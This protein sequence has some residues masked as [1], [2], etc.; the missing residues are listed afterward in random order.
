MN[1]RRRL[2]VVAFGLMVAVAPPTRA[3][4]LP[5]FTLTGQNWSYN[6]GD[7]GSTITGILLTPYT[8]VPLPAV[9]ISHGKGGSAGGFS[10]PKA[11]LMTNWGLVCIGPDY[12]H[13]GA[14]S[15]P[16][17][18]GYCPENSR[19]ARA[20]LTILRSLAYVDTNRLA[21]Y[22]N[23][24]GAFL[25]AGFCGEPASP[26]RAAAI[27]AGGTS[28]TANTN[29][30]SPTVSEVN[31]VRAPFLLL[32]GTADTTVPP[33]QSA[34]LQAVLNSNGVPN[35]R[36]LFGD[37]GHDL[38]NNPATSNE[39]NQLIREWF[40]EWGVLPALQLTVTR[41]SSNARVSWPSGARD[42]FEVQHRGAL[43]AGS[44]Q[45]VVANWPAGVSNRTQWIHTNALNDG[46]GFYR[47]SRSP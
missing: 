16:E 28:G 8:N 32:H 19:R 2:A 37:I 27:T 24:M 10:L 4:G 39:V 44:W 22:G 30:A 33:Q 11:R 41:E 38:H 42:R 18:E 12:T 26:L 3:Q 13:A 14:G 35:S 15:T 45:P 40:T 36:V 20:C 5:G 34:S 7:G 9:L 1:T 43:D 31:A 6:P 23:S 29:F 17:N 46:A 47:V 25:T 21:A